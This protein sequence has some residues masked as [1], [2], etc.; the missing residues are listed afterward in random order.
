MNAE[1]DS[2]LRWIVIYIFNVQWNIYEIIKKGLTMVWSYFGLILLMLCASI[3]NQWRIQDLALGE[4]EVGVEKI[5]DY[6]WWWLV[7]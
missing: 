4:A 1:T 2:P 3:L 5:I 7:P 6:L